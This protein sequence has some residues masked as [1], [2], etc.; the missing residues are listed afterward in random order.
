LRSPFAHT[1]SPEVLAAMSR[2]PLP[3]DAWT[4]L[5]LAPALVFVATATDRNYQ[6]DLWHHLARGRAIAAEG[7]LLDADRFTFTVAGKPF[8]DCNWIWQVLFYRV[9]ELGGLSLVQAVN[10]AVLAL[11]VG[12]L[13]HLAWRRCGSSTAAAGVGILAFFGL[14]QVMIIRPQTFS[15]LL[16]V[17]LL[18]VCE[19]GQRRRWLLVLAPV[20]LALWANLHGGF[21]VGLL[22]VGCYTLATGLEHVTARRVRSALARRASEGEEDPRLRVGLTGAAS[23]AA[24]VVCLA[25]CVGATLLNPYGWRVYQYVLLTSGVAAARR[26]DEWLPPGLGLL[27]GK[28]WVLSLVLLVVLLARQ[29]R[30]LAWSDLCL[31]CVFLPLACGSVRM[32]AWWLLV[33]AP[34]L[35]ELLAAYLP[36]RQ[37]ADADRPSW[38]AAGA[39]AA[40]LLACVVSLPWLERFNPALAVPGRA[41]RTESDLQLVA[42]HLADADGGRVFT[43]FAWGEYLGWAVGPGCT[44][45]MDGRIEI[46]PDEVWAEYS[47]ITR[48][49]A[50]W[51]AILARRGVDHLLLD[52]SGYHAE[53]LQQVERSPAWRE[54]LRQGDAVLFVRQERRAAQR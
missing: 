7:R 37:A 12:L 39:C 15:L 48:G 21:P 24:W 47:A 49:R 20:V 23:V 38:G 44:I 19:A 5:L 43:R 14:W 13:G 40:M 8:Q 42:D 53:L 6:T 27:I 33:S 31:V 26:I 46:F 22:L 9:H 30:R 51:E 4:R 10:S 25:A 29:G 34:I 36:A 54:V 32:I 16:F 17:L 3:T 45:F 18:S 28:V 2:L 52:A 1:R 11:V 41:H 35:A 50:D